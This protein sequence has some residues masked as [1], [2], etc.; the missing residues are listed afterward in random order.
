LALRQYLK[1]K[2]R[3][4]FSAIITGMIIGSIA[5]LNAPFLLV[6]I[7]SLAAIL[8]KHFIKVKHN[9]IF[10]PATLGLVIGL[11]AFG[12]GDVW[13]A[14]G[15]YSVSGFTFSLAPLLIIAA[16]QSRRLYASAAFI[17]AILAISIVLTGASS[18]D[19]LGGIDA[20]IFGVNYYFAFLMLADPKTSPHKTSLQVAYG[21]LIA[22]LYSGFA[23]YRIHYAFLLALLVGNLL[24]ALYRIKMK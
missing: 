1:Q 17:T 7:A 12:L 18:I 4:P 13:W 10:N 5:P 19:S 16:Y 6:A 21:I 24:Y 11:A 23:I 8:S 14:S 2:H 20:L 3:I 22:L 15:S 9:P